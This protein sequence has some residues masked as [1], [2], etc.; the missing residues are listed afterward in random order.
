MRLADAA[1]RCFYGAL[2]SNF[3]H[4]VGGSKWRFIE[5]RAVK[6]IPGL[7]T[8][9]GNDRALYQVYILGKWLRGFPYQKKR[10]YRALPISTS[11]NVLYDS[12]RVSYYGRAWRLRTIWPYGFTHMNNMDPA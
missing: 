2:V 12:L 3:L 7:L 10:L 6:R 1:P 9:T 5:N 4:T 11:L 8:F